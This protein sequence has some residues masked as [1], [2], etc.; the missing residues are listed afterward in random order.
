MFQLSRAKKR[1]D[2]APGEAS[3]RDVFLIPEFCAMTGLTEEMRNDRR[4]MQDLAQYTRVPPDQRIGR[5]RGYLGS[6][7]ESVF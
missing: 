4:I 7:V 6:L 1:G 2:V 3:S 5:A